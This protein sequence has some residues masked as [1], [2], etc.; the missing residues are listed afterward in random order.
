MV[1]TS[2]LE[3]GK[4]KGWV[5]IFKSQHNVLWYLGVKKERLIRMGQECSPDAHFHFH[6]V[7]KKIKGNKEKETL[8]YKQ[9]KRLTV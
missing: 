3:T 6:L 5:G 9:V 8:W 7:L 2:R 4:D 1:Y